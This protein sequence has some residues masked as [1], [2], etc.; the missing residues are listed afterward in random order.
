MFYWSDVIVFQVQYG[1][2]S[3][4]CASL[5][6]KSLNDQIEVVKSLVKRVSPKDYGAYYLSDE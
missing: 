6:G 3:H 5:K 1:N 2:R 4:F